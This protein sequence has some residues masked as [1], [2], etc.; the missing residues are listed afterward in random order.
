MSKQ[1]TP[2]AYGP[3]GEAVVAFLERVE[4]LTSEELQRL[5]A[6]WNGTRSATAWRAA[7]EAVRSASRETA[8][9][10]W[11]DAL[12]GVRRAERGTALPSARAAAADVAVALSVRDL[13]TPEQFEVLS[14]PWREVI[15]D[16]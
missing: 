13:I 1:R 6:A 12:E 5:A 8:R 11:C 2:E 3:N 9:P 7:L 14:A 15:G 4:R 10:A 16:A